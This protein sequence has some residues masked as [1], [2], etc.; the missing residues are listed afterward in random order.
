MT[1][2]DAAPEQSQISDSDR[3]WRRRRR[4]GIAM[5]AAGGL[6]LLAGL[7]LAVTAVM[8]RSQL[9]QVRADARTLGAR[10]SASNWPAA[11][12]TAADLAN[13]AHRANQL[14]SGPVWALAAALPSGGEPL[15]TIR[16]ITAGADAIGRDALPQLVSAGE[17]LNPRTLRRPDG[18]VDLSRIAAVAPAL[19]SASSAVT[20]A[21]RDISG[22]PAHTWLSSIDSSYVDALSQVSA[23]SHALKSANLAAQILPEMLG[24]DGPKRYFLG[25]QN[26]AEARGTGGLPGAFA[27]VEANHGTVQFTRMESNTRLSDAAATVNFGPDFQR[28]YNEAAPTTTYVNSNLSPHFPYAAQIW[29]SMWTNY[30]GEKVDGVLAVDP[31][32]LGYLL[33][34][35]GPA[36]LPDKSQITGDNAVALTQSTNYAKFGGLGADETDRRK[37]YQLDIA[38][39]ASHKILDSLGDP[40]A[41]LR[42]AGKAAGERRILVWS[43]DPSV[44]ADLAQ[45]SIAGIIPATTAPYAGL[46]IVNGAGSKLDYYLDRS[47]TWQR[48]GCGPTRRTTVTIT[49]TNNAPAHGLPQYVTIRGDRRSY[50]IKLGDNR[51]AVSY[52]A[53]QGA[54]VRD[55]TVAGRPGR[56]RIGA[57]RGHPVYTV[58]LELPRGSSRTIVLHLIEPAGTGAPIV[59]RQPLVRPLQVTI[60]DAICP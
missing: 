24:Q 23:L 8:A 9:N 28:L 37:A 25:F 40:A 54:L 20:Q 57:E 32:A 38:S 35:T 21:T 31:T 36:T 6:L 52:F 4:I 51:I 22:L 13:H 3:R 17:R 47:L 42:A 58:D 15:K 33:A 5:I 55:I 10:I 43:A 50:P 53:T 49:L 45:T 44:Q 16:G 34:V 29:A 39:A 48:S 27:I 18:S 19:G 11:R 46:S 59:L 26:E 2:D 41:L 7:W 14:T 1:E 60:K 56:G 12:A 30:S